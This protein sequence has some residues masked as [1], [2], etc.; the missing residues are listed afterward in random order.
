VIEQHVS[1]V[2]H[3]K[4]SSQGLLCMWHGLGIRGWLK[5][6]QYRPPVTAQYAFRW[7]SISALSVLTSGLNALESAVY[8]RRVRRTT[9]EKPPIFILGH[10]RSGTT[11]LHNL[12][13]LD[14]ELTFANLYQCMSPGHFL[15]TEAITPR[16][17]SFLIPR[18]RPM[19]N[20]ATSWHTPQ[21]DEIA[22]ALDCGLSPY[23]MTAFPVRPEIYSRYF[24]PRDMST[25]EREA[26]KASLMRF[27]QKLTYRQN[28]SVVL[29]SPGHTYRIP[30]LLEM[31]PD[32]K[33][34]YLHRDPYRVYS[35]SMHLRRTMFAE[36]A[37]YPSDMQGSEAEMVNLYEACIRKYEATKSLIP[38]GNLYELPFES[39]E[40]DPLGEVAAL[41]S[42][43]GLP[44]W[45][46]VEP[47]IRAEL[48][49]L[50]AYR[51]NSFQMDLATRKKIY[52][53]LGWIFELY[54]YPDR[55]SDRDNAA[56]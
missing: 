16:M 12:M 9:I 49:K 31:F 54:G 28:K 51:K 8:S 17:T 4:K 41:Y 1:R 20:V 2:P 19:D 39:L 10:W 14:P 36:N 37:L 25:E 34:I 43:L 29:K 52:S 33:F 46:S 15:L 42:N 40:A 38:A 18:T 7:A 22:L 48:P 32:A 45:T 21:E 5:M 24:D 27:I 23:L 11:L 30:T 50:A 53:R 3:V 35:S 44:S 47:L 13:C 26:W 56:A 55:L 6:L